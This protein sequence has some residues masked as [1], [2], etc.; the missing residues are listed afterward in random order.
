[1]VEVG[2][3]GFPFNPDA[4]VEDENHPSAQVAISMQSPHT[5]VG[6]RRF[7]EGIYGHE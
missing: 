7:C 3:R 4:S 2:K 1:M 5:L 6:Y